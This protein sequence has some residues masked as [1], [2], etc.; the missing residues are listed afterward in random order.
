LVTTPGTYQV[1]SVS[2]LQFTL[3]SEPLTIEAA[4]PLIIELEMEPPTCNGSTDGS[5]TATF[6]NMPLQSITWN[7]GDTG[8]TTIEGLGSGGYSF[9]AVDSYGCQGAD[10]IFLPEPPLLMASAATTD[11]LCAGDATGTATVNAQGGTPPYVMDW[12]G[13]DPIALAAG[14]GTMLLMDAN[15]CTLDVPYTISQPE[16]LLVFATT[17][18]DPGDGTGG[19]AQ[20][21]I[22]GGVP[23][24][25]ILWSNG[26]TDV[27]AVEGLDAGP[28][29]VT[30]TDAN[31]CQT[32]IELLIGMTSVADLRDDQP[33][34]PYPNPTTGTLWL[35]HCP[36]PKIALELLDMAGRR[37][38]HMDAHDCQAPLELARLSPGIYILR[39]TAGRRVVDAPIL[40]QAF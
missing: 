3:T 11:V 15:D 19:G 9:M 35:S 10:G 22:A 39:M 16:E 40:F 20:V 4:P 25:A 17:L 18:P 24:Y 27:T 14:S 8:I 36:E 21:S 38:L 12:S 13:L 6:S 31:D 26:Q 2:D 5:I 37:V 32:T 7:T 23:P 33:V 29:Q 28:Y 1:T 34:V 30:V